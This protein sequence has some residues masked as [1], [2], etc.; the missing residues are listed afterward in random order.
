MKNLIYILVFIIPCL[1]NSQ[2]IQ[3]KAGLG[4]ALY[5]QN[6]DSL[7][8]RL[9]LK[10]IDGAVVRTVIPGSNADI[11]K[12]LPNDIITNINYVD[13]KSASE[14]ILFAQK[15]K[16][17][18]IINVVLNRKNKQ[19][20]LN[21][22]LV[23]KPYEISTEE[24]KVSY[25]EFKFENTLIRTITKTP[26]KLKSKGVVYFIQGISCYSVD[27]LNPQDPTKL[28]IDAFVKLGYTVF[29][30][31]KLGMGDSYYHCACNEI[32]FKKELEVF[33]EGYKHLINRFPN[34][35]IIL[36]GHSLGGITAPLIAQKFKTNA[37]IVYGTGLK[38]W[39]DYLLDAYLV[40]SRY[41]QTDL[42]NQRDTLEKVKFT[43]YKLFYETK[44]KDFAITDPLAKLASQAILNYNPQSGYFAAERTL[45]FHQEINEHNLAKAWK[46]TNTKVLAI[47]GESDIAANNK[48]DTEEIAR[49]IN[50][51]RPGTAQFMFVPKTNHTFQKIGT[52]QD[53]VKL[54]SEDPA[55]YQ[56][57]ALSQF[58]H[59]LFKDID[60]WL[61]NNL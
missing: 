18:E 38:P 3:R 61:N 50:E 29:T 9:N 20:K 16:Q 23:G 11:L 57:F 46:N 2:T 6:S 12:I 30:A 44:T 54:E 43:L 36:F 53:F 58:N 24:I 32:G 21:G 49:Y 45:Q 60:V 10:P 13:I 47:Y 7:F 5:S 39:S 4:V 1:I 51:L 17:G 52:M 28:A 41:Y 59:D 27:N 25:G 33:T 15:L 35:K 8:K 34:Q 31:E 14:L 56:L 48:Y 55:K 40:Q 42:A 22:E 26:L 37:V 19:I